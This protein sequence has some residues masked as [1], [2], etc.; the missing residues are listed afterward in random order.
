[1]TQAPLRRGTDETTRLGGLK[2]L[3]TILRIIPLGVL[4]GGLVVIMVTPLLRPWNG[5]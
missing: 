2:M 1:M 4:A 5:N 3:E